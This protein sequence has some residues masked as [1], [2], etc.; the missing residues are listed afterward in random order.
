MFF[1]YDKIK[2]LGLPLPYGY[3]YGF[4][5]SNSL[6]DVFLTDIQNYMVADILVKTDTTSMANGLELRAP[7]LD[8]KFAEFAISLPVAFKYQ[9]GENK[10]ILRELIKKHYP[11]LE[12]QKGK[13]GFGAPIE[14]WLKLKEFDEYRNYVKNDRSAL[15]YRLIDFT[16]MSDRLALNNYRTWAVINLNAWLEVQVG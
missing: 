14:D 16:K 8:V 3:W 15:V 13:L 10:L 12:R 1:S 4:T 7:F 2:T 11:Y 5:S 9:G 6:N